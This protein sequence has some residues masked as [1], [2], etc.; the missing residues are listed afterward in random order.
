MIE[1]SR[2][3]LSSILFGSN[4]FFYFTSTEYGAEST[5]LKPLLHTWSLGVEEQFY[6][7]FPLLVVVIFR[8]FRKFFLSILVALSLLSLQFAE[9]VE[10]INPAP[11]FLS[12]FY[13]VLGVSRWLCARI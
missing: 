12:T 11:K 5:L 4:F 7:V 2:S 9:L 8:Y 6:L 3:V 1:Y 13:S 10:V